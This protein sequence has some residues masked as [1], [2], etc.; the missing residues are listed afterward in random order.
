M[1]LCYVTA[2]YDIDRAGWSTFSRTFD[3]YFESFSKIADA[4]SSMNLEFVVFIDSRHYDRVASHIGL[5]ANI[6]II[7]IDEAFLNKNVHA[8]SLLKREEE[9]MHSDKYRALVS[10][11][12]RFPENTKPRYT[13]ITHAK[14]DFVNI[15]SSICSADVMCWVDF[16]YVHF[17]KER[18]DLSRVDVTKVN[19]S[20][21][22]PLDSRDSDIVY[23]LR[24]APEKVSS[25]VFFGHRSAMR[26]F[27]AIYHSQLGRLQS[28]NLADDDQHL[29]LLCFFERPGLFTFHHLGWYGILKEYAQS[30]SDYVNTITI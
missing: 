18:L 3:K 1:S 14:I 23:T 7:S 19:F 22:N 29:V 27:Q 25:G 8:W 5:R 17:P 6:R 11:R 13:T 28:M 12:L 9:I 21:V 30:Q 24:E 16:G 10:H 4:I 26:E 15:A 2:F 20:L